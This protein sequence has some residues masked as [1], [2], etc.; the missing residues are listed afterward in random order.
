MVTGDQAGQRFHAAFLIQRMNFGIGAVIG[1][2]FLDQQM[3]VGQCSDLGC[4]GDAQD[5]VALRTLTQ[6]F[7][8]APSSLAGNTATTAAH[9]PQSLPNAAQT[10]C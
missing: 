7:A 5:L 2:I 4:M 6:N 8:D 10:L 3:A 1:H 9:W